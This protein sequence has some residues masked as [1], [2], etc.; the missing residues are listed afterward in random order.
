[1]VRNPRDIV[2]T[3]I[4]LC[5]LICSVAFAEPYAVRDNRAEEDVIRWHRSQGRTPAEICGILTSYFGRE[6]WT[7]DGSVY[8]LTTG[9][10][11]EMSYFVI[12]EI[13]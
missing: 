13:K 2:K 3:L 1:M 8:I 10:H 9:R 7:D 5:C 11:T 6:C 12:I 4:T